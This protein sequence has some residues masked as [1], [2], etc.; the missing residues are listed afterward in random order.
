MAIDRKEE[1][2]S[3]RYSISENFVLIPKWEEWLRYSG[4]ET[5]EQYRT[6]NC[7]TT[8]LCSNHAPWSISLKER[9]NT[10]PRE[11]SVLNDL[12]CTTWCI[13]AMVGDEF[14]GNRSCQMPMW[15]LL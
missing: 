4:L 15:R 1:S 7:K 11:T 13:S 14:G 12:S 6:L 5:N 2:I 9:E 3:A 8:E 10:S